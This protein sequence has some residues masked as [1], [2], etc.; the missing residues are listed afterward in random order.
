M[1]A[2]IVALILERPLC[3]DCIA[4]K[5]EAT[6]TQIEATLGDQNVELFLANP[7]HGR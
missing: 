4:S 1:A 2:L 5:V 3:F 6:P 7:E